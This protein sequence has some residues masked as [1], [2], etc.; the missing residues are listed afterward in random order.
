MSELS[1]RFTAERASFPGPVLV[2]GA[3]GCIGS[4]VLALLARSG[5]PACAFDLSEDKRRPRL[6]IDEKDL[7][8]I[9]WRT[10]DISDS[11][12]VMRVLE[13]VRPCAIIHLAALQVPF[14]KA[15]PVAGAK[16]NV[17]GT[18]NVFEA[19]RKLGIKRLAYASSIA[20][21]GAMD[22]DLGAM[23]TL[24]GAYKHCD[25]QIALVYS[26]DWG[27]ASVGIRPGVV[28]GVG[29][30]QGLTSKT[31][32]AILA[33][34]AGKPYDVPFSGGVSWLYAAEVASAF[35]RAVSRERAGAP[36]FD[37][38]GVYAPVEEGLRILKQIA[39]AAAVTSSG[40]A[41]A[42]PMHLPDEPLR[43]YLGDY[44]SATLAEGIRETYDAFRSL[45]ARGLLS[46]P[47]PV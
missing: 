33:A 23:H 14:C 21:Y 13:D 37:M 47:D 32:V 4:W 44:G 41:L 22:E 26:G 16:V 31:T 9:A 36:V 35:I 3:G 39:P 8:K 24:Y 19:A 34:A 28:Y 43:A 2:T 5:V 29:R 46:A 20:A 42:F 25:E 10:G 12:A 30:D 45:V 6:L 11:A 18:V 1:E 15:D 38:N 27:V 7:A 40:Q 17:V